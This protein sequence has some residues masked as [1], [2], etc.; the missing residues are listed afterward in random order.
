MCPCASGARTLLCVCVCV[1][2]CVP[3]CTPVSV[4][5]SVIHEACAQPFCGELVLSPGGF[6]LVAPTLTG[7]AQFVWVGMTICIAIAS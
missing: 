7:V 5:V 2:V 3:V 1:H 4:H 6:A